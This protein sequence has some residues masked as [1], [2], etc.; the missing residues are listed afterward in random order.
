MVSSLTSADSAAKMEAEQHKPNP[1]Q[2]TS[3]LLQSFMGIQGNDRYGN[4]SQPW[5]QHSKKRKEEF[6][7]SI[8]EEQQIKK[9]QGWRLSRTQS[10]LTL[11]GFR[12]DKQKSQKKLSNHP[13]PS[14]QNLGTFWNQDCCSGDSERECAQASREHH[15]KN[16]TH[17]DQ[18]RTLGIGG[19]L[20]NLSSYKGE[21]GQSHKSQ[22]IWRKLSRLKSASIE[23]IG[24]MKNGGATDTG[25]QERQHDREHKA[26]YFEPKE[27]SEDDNGWASGI[28]GSALSLPGCREDKS[29]S[30]KAMYFSSHM[31]WQPLS[32]SNPNINLTW[33][34]SD[35]GNSTPPEKFVRGERRTCDHEKAPRQVCDVHI[36]HEDYLK[37]TSHTHHRYPEKGQSEMAQVVQER[38]MK[39]ALF[40]NSNISWDKQPEWN[41]QGEHRRNGD[42]RRLT[43]EQKCKTEEDR[44]QLETVQQKEN[45]M[46]T[47]I[48]KF[49]KHQRE[50]EL[51][52]KL[53][54]VRA[55]L[56]ACQKAMATQAERFATERQAWQVEKLQVLTYQREL[57]REYRA[58]R[59]RSHKLKVML[60]MLGA[61]TM[62]T[63]K[64]EVT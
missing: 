36:P 62:S 20:L 43:E 31:L 1:G 14:L 42:R 11:F 21:N 50:E 22:K 15:S 60:Q 55:E 47:M 44:H 12:S 16:Q 2:S 52:Q 26:H 32:A 7:T 37:L 58:E 45:N 41:Y 27:P 29:R 46:A 57:Q 4:R 13:S 3:G 34:T 25:E 17:K 49:I 40:R 28:G 10:E 38:A 51:S 39:N 6:L 23:K 63:L 64:E 30:R 53:G 61:G 9:A 8:R 54:V 48:E 56:A 33:P 18:G 35:H 5:K 24:T 59:E 19:S